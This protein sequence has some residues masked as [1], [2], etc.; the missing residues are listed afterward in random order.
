MG[1]CIESVFT[2]TA[3]LI[4]LITGCVKQESTVYEKVVIDKMQNSGT[5][6][7]YYATIQA[8]EAVL[9]KMNDILDDGNCGEPI[10]IFRSKEDDPDRVFWFPVMD[11]DGSVMNVKAVHMSGEGKV[12]QVNLMDVSDE[13]NTIAEYTSNEEPLY[14]VAGD[15][16]TYYVVGDKAY[17]FNEIDT[18]TVSVGEFALPA[19]EVTVKVLE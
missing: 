8:D 1:K 19:D 15:I 3:V 7:L 4:L 18:E 11:K 12:N 9:T 6:P 14:I 5:M 10:F 17:V 13:L 2:L 16:E